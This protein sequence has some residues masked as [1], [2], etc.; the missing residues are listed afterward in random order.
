MKERELRAAADCAICGKPFGHTGL[1]MFWRVTIERHGVL[2]DRM[3]RQDGLAAML[4]GN[5]LLAQVM[6]PDEEMTTPLLGPVTVTVCE[7]CAAAPQEYP[8]AFLAERATDKQK[9][10]A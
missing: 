3:K 7:H 4:G 5:S 8:I 1:P 10:P 6:G 9:D 2:L